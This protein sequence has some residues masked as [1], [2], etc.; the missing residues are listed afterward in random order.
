MADDVEF[1]FGKGL[2]SG[3]L[4]AFLG[5]LS[6][7]G[8]LCFLFPQVL[9]AEEVRAAY[10][11]D[12]VRWILFGSLVVAYFMGIISFVLNRS[13]KLAII[14]IVSSLI[15]TILGGS[16]IEVTAYNSTPY[17][18]GLDWFALS[19]I[20]SMIIFIPIE[21]SFAL[22]KEQKILRKEWRTDL[23]Y[24]FVSHLLIQFIMLFVTTF[25]EDWF[26]WL[27]IAGVQ[28]SIRSM[29]IWLQILVAV[30]TADLCQYTC[31]RFHH[32]IP[33][34][35]RFHSVHHSAEHMDW[36]AGSRTH[37]I[38]I[39]VTR[40]LVMLPLYALG[41][42]QTALNAYITIVGIQAVAIHA[43]VGVNL[44]WLRYIIVTPQFHHWHHAKDH[45]YMDAN[46][47]VHL[48]LID[49]MFGTF[50][51]PKGE[52]P[53]EYGIVSGKPPKGIWKQFLHPL[54]KRKKK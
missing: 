12:V 39:I 52:W 50:R 1:K 38:E 13:K 21:R 2:I 51:C 9:T 6:L 7:M 28:E 22:H 35:W 37:L 4:S 54:K 25:V 31:H 29:P 33:K 30:F 48:P 34:L 49:M 53:K 18:F 15:A 26:G 42:E 19:L 45:D 32:K 36:L 11:T 5:V 10:S 24:F 20:F 43:N 14:G 16:G 44:S 47:A 23:A 40:S 3:Y 8:V 41:F 17:S 46:Y 27:A